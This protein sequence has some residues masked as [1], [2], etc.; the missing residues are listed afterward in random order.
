MLINSS[1]MAPGARSLIR[2][3]C[4]DPICYDHHKVICPER[5]CLVADYRET[6][7]NYSDQVRKLADLLHA[8]AACEIDVLRRACRTAW[9]LAEK[10]RLALARHEANHFCDRIDFIAP[11]LPRSKP[12][13]K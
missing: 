12:A 4:D 8:G 11:Q 6:T 3:D 2:F 1:R 5:L 10:A 9:E 13:G 7:R